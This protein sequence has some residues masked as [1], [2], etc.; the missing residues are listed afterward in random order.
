MFSHAHPY[1]GKIKHEMIEAAGFSVDRTYMT[2]IVFLYTFT[3]KS[4]VMATS[5][6]LSVATM[7]TSFTV[8]FLWTACFCQGQKLNQLIAHQTMNVIYVLSTENPEL[9]LFSLIDL[10]YIAV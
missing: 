4:S 7:N 3:C 10:L 8:Y 6:V 5:C 9:L 2:F 1:I